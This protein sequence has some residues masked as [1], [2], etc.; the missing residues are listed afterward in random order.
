MVMHPSKRS[1]CRERATA[2]TR[3]T[4]RPSPYAAAPAPAHPSGARARRSRPPPRPAVELRRGEAL[5]GGGG[6]GRGVHDDGAARTGTDRQQMPAPP[7]QRHLGTERQPLHERREQAVRRLRGK[8]PPEPVDREP[9]AE[10]VRRPLGPGPGAE[11][12]RRLGP[13]GAWAM[14]PWRQGVSAEPRGRLGPSAVRRRAEPRPPSISSEAGCPE[15][16]SPLP[17]RATRLG[18]RTRC[19]TRPG[20]PPPGPATTGRGGSHARRRFRSLEFDMPDRPVLGIDLG[21]EPGRACPASRAPPPTV[22]ELV[23][24]S[25]R[26]A[27]PRTHWWPPA[28]RVIKGFRPAEGLPRPRSPEESRSTR[29]PGVWRAL[30]SSRPRPTTFAGFLVLGARVF[31]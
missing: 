29:T 6:T 1:D 5:A 11:R 16:W 30:R 28:L 7:L 9:P 22:H 3:H 20:G 8:A 23:S 2:A 15:S 17:G 24:R 13:Y 25:S 31:L 12:C 18:S 21:R 4:F 26:Q 14:P 27:S 10:A 19:R